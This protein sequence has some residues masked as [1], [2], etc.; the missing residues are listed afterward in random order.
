MQMTMRQSRR[1]KR[2]MTYVLLVLWAIICLFPIYWLIITSVKLPIAV[3]QG[4]K[5]L[6]WI[7][8]EPSLHAWEYVL[9]GPLRDQVRRS[10]MP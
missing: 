4:P 3:F 9:I 8:F 2:S 1:V 6:P 7:D 10:W 5:Y